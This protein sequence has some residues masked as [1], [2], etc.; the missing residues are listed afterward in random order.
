[1]RLFR[2][3][4][5]L[6]TLVAPTAFADSL[7]QVEMIL[8]RQ[9]G[10]PAATLQFAP[11]DWS[12]GAKRI[13]SGNE[14]SPAL[15]DMAKKLQ[16]SGKYQVLLQKAWQQNIGTENS[17]MAVTSGQEQLGHFPVEGTISL[18]IARFTDVS[19]D[20]WINQLDP[21]GIL[22]SSE[23]MKQ[24]ARVKNGELIYLDN[25]NLAVLIKVSPL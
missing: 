23:H 21:H 10:E 6:L 22:I 20:F 11:E 15:N 8:F 3:L 24:T 13:D 16:D 2:S 5:L 7:Y 14:R 9:L 4:I 12:A 19:A 17:K 25:S 1:M 18:A